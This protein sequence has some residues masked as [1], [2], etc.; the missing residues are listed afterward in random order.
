MSPCSNL[1]YICIHGN[2]PNMG[3]IYIYI[4]IDSL[5]IFFSFCK[6]MKKNFAPVE[7]IGESV[8][9][10]VVEGEIPDDLQEGVYIRNGNKMKALKSLWF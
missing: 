7:E 2:F 10:F 6:N 3:A 4:Y 5:F 9:V 1:K 8:D